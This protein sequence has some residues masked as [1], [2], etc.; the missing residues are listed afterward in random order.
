MSFLSRKLIFLIIP[1][2]LNELHFVE[3]HIS[4]VTAAGQM[5]A[6]TVG[7]NFEIKTMSFKSKDTRLTTP[8]PLCLPHKN[9]CYLDS[10]WLRLPS[11]K[12]FMPIKSNDLPQILF[13]WEELLDA[14]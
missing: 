12:P 3:V 4:Q 14:N 5:L 9:S 13:V 10:S 7:S 2:P 6:S 8:L 1:T 11:L